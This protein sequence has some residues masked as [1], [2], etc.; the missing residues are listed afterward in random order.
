MNKVEV[1]VEVESQLIVL[2]RI[3]KLIFTVASSCSGLF[4]GCVW[5]IHRLAELVH[6][7][8]ERITV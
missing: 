6:Y 8:W 1:E 4:A 5:L 2:N 3:E 7:W